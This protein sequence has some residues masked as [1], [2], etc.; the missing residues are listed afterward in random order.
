MNAPR[1]GDAILLRAEVASIGPDGWMRVVI[2]TDDARDK[3]I[4]I[5]ARDPAIER[6][7]ETIV[8]ALD[9]VA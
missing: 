9:E 7:G 5:N 1:I 8:L 6:A 4:I 3:Q 2:R